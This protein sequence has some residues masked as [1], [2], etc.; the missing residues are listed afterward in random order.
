MTIVALSQALRQQ[1][2][3]TILSLGTRTEASGHTVV[4]GVFSS[5][6]GKDYIATISRLTST[7]KKIPG[8]LGTNFLHK[9][10]YIIL[11]V[12]ADEAF[13]AGTLMCRVWVIPYQI[14]VL[15]ALHCD[16]QVPV[17]QVSL[18]SR[19]TTS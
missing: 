6:T 11:L 7:P 9:D 15:L 5:R 3:I 12:E 10:V 14:V 17:L 16:V 1:A 8:A 18:C 2:S 13:Y 19:C 4:N